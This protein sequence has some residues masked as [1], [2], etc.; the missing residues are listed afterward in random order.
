MRRILLILALMCSCAT[1]VGQAFLGEWAGKI[2]ID[3]KKTDARSLQTVRTYK[4]AAQRTTLSLLLRKDKT[5]QAVVFNQNGK[6]MT[7]SGTWEKH[8]DKDKKQS[9]LILTATEANGVKQSTPGITELVI[10]KDGKTL[11]ATLED[12]VKTTK[13][14][15]TREAGKKNGK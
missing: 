8:D 9:K 13:W 1:M 5:F 14:V 4:T 2:V 12:E 10:S 6:A 7:M 11:T 15:Y 3:A